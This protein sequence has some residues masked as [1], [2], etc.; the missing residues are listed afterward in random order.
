M[1]KIHI[2]KGGKPLAP[3]IYLYGMSGIGK[4]TFAVGCPCPLII[5][6]DGGAGRYSVDI[7]K[8]SSSDEILDVLTEV[9]EMDYRTIVIDTLEAL[10]RLIYAEICRKAN[11][12]SIEKA[13]G[14]YSKG[15]IAAGE[16]MGTIL[17]ALSA[18]LP[19]RKMP[20][21]L[22]QA[23]VKKITDPEGEYTQFSPRANKH[24]SNRVIE[25]A[26]LVLFATREQS[27]ATGSG[28]R[29]MF[30]AP[31]KR[32]IAKSRLPLPEQVELSFVPIAAALKQSKAVNEEEEHGGF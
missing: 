27:S 15:H 19:L 18:L 2:T 14:G 30:T 10:E 9:Q 8:V 11:V 25:W 22:G 1:A 20:V 23:D 16:T 32:A 13:F 6:L 3:K 7:V 31:T 26:D 4:T 24:L 17:D 28:K 12:D 21:V 29:V 5:D